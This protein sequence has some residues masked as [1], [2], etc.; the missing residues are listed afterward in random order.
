[1]CRRPPPSSG[2]RNSNLK[3]G[4]TKFRPSVSRHC[5]LLPR[6]RTSG[7]SLTEGGKVRRLIFRFTRSQLVPMGT[8]KG[9]AGL[10][11]LSGPDDPAQ[12]G[13]TVHLPLQHPLFNEGVLAQGPGVLTQEVVGSPPVPREDRLLIGSTE[14]SPHWARPG[15][16]APQG[17]HRQGG[18]R[19]GST[20]QGRLSREWGTPAG[21]GGALRGRQEA[22][23]QRRGAVPGSE[24]DGLQG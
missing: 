23:A 24:P 17:R 4:S 18:R 19:A 21:L 6:A 1:M 7:G 14:W 8:E 3:K 13:D 20:K 5:Q 12:P 11:S 2:Q 9:R 16:G 22:Y 10:P 15:D